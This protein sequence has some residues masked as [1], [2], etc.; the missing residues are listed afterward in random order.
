[1]SEAK[2]PQGTPAWFEMVGMLMCRTAARAGL[3]PDLDVSFVER[4]IDGTAI[5]GGL[6]QGI[7]FDIRGGKPSFR[8]GVSPDEKTHVT[9]EITAA[10]AQELNRLRSADPA[11]AAARDRFLRTGEMRINGDPN[12]LGDWLAVVHDPIVD[13]TIDPLGQPSTGA[14]AQDQ[15]DARCCALDGQ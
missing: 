1:M 8:E 11:Y 6:V 4:Y 5:G 15:A 2:L 3:A 12:R 14:A 7:R 13:R 9:V 10:A